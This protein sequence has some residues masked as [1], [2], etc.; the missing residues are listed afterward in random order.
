MILINT[1]FS[2]TNPK[3]N[4]PEKEFEEL[5]NKEGYDEKFAKDLFNQTIETS[6][7][8]N[9]VILKLVNDFPQ[10]DFII[11]PHPFENPDQ[12]I[13]LIK[14]KN[15]IQLK[16]EGTV[17][18]CI[19]QSDL[20][21][22]QNCSTAIESLLIGIEPLNWKWISGRLLRQ[23]VSEKVS[24]NNE[25]YVQ[26]YGAVA[27]LNNGLRLTVSKTIEK[28]R[29]KIIEDWFYKA[30]GKASERVAD[31]IESVIKQKTNERKK[32]SLF[33]MYLLT[34]KNR[35]FK[36]FIY[37][38]VFQ[39]TGTKGLNNIKRILKPVFN[40]KMNIDKIFTVS[41]IN[42]LLEDILKEVNVT[43]V[44]KMNN[45]KNELFQSIHLNWMQSK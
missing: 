40:K 16:Q 17:F 30:D 29:K 9:E 23:P 26:I 42:K 35:D 27:K 34:L 33:R 8:F 25:S 37:Q 3:Y 12:Y 31:K 41:M 18:S 11:R 6:I 44:Y 21:I 2:F 38:L 28:E 43:S 10:I 45:F 1:N 36:Q 5:I 32:Y 15:N 13:S 4:T 19:A 22:H 7:K 14:N 24:T 20:L 39:I